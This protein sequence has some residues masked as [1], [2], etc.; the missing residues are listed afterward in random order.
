[1]LTGSADHTVRLFDRRRAGVGSGGAAV[2]LVHTFRGHTDAVNA[3][4]WCPDRGGVL[5]SASTDGLVNVW[6]ADRVGSA[7]GG[8]AG[9]SEPAPELIFQ[10]AGHAGSPV[11]DFHWSPAV[12]WTCVSVSDNTNGGGTIQVWRIT[13]LLTRPEEEVLA[14][15]DKHRESLLTARSSGAPDLP[16][17]G[18]EEDPMED[19]GDDGGS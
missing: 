11:V 15:L 6:D 18:A 16:A 5:A 12:P 9:A 13:D 19:D 1:V 3:V 2:A 4:Q 10:H 7:A 14:E 8:A 17:A